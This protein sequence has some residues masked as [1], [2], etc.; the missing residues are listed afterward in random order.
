MTIKWILHREDIIPVNL[1]APSLGIP[2]YIKG[3]LT[4]L[5]GGTD[6]NTGVVGA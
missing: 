4:D 6:K 2:K 1:C 3:L 5:K